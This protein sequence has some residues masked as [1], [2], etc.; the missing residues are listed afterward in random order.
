MSG[1]SSL[2][3]PVTQ[4]AQCVLL[5]ALNGL[6]GVLLP[7]GK[8]LPAVAAFREVLSTGECPPPPPPP[9]SP[10]PT[11]FPPTHPPRPRLPMLC[12]GCPAS[13]PNSQR[14]PVKLCH[15]SSPCCQGRLYLRLRRMLADMFNSGYQQC[16]RRARS[17]VGKVIQGKSFDLDNLSSSGKRS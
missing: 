5:G 1:H 11:P 9:G 16:I 17:V 7:E 10:P 3:L 8:I 13:L 15:S 6:A 2:G 12:H 4:D 14:V